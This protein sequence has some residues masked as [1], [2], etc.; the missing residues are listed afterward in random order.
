MARDLIHV[1]N[2]TKRL[3]AEE[4]LRGIDLEVV[5]GETLV[6]IG[7]SGGGKSVFLKHIIGLMKPTSG[8]VYVDDE[9]VVAMTER[10][11]TK[12]RKKVGILF[13]SAAL[14]DSMSVE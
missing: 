6:I 1:R 2:L 12:I 9:N 3:G 14:F 10:Q 4:V 5:A 11:L 8:E 7:R 13:Q